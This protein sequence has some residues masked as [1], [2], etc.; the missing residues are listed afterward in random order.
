MPLSVEDRL[1]I[2]ELLGL[3]GHLTDD[4]QPERLDELFTADATYD[5]EKFGAGI[6]CG[7][8]QLRALATGDAAQRGPIAHH[9]TNVIIHVDADE[10]V[11]VKSKGLGVLPDGRV[12]SVVYDDVVVQ[13]PQ[14]WRIAYRVVTHRGS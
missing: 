4:K 13:T 11:R 6:H 3:H 8:D 12:G 9:V 14:G 2:H 7:I 5:L 1:A 10:T